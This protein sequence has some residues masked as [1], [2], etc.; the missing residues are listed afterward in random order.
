MSSPT[1]PT[2]RPAAS[3]SVSSTTSNSSTKSSTTSPS[4][5]Q[6]KKSIP[7]E[8]FERCDVCGQR[9]PLDTINRGKCEEPSCVRHPDFAG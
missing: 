9:S 3:H 4:K 5:H 7:P 2:T 1:K 8:G 6:S